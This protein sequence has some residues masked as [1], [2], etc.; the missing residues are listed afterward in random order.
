M[1]NSLYEQD[2]FAWANEQAAL[3]RSGKLHDID[4]ENIAEEIESMDRSHKSE[5]V[6]RLAVLFAASL[7]MA[8]P[9]RVSQ[10]QL[11]PD[12]QPEQRFHIE[13]HMRDN[14]G[15]KSH[16]AEAMTDAFRSCQDQSRA[17]DRTARAEF[18]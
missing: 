16:L 15:L 4:I 12:H 9:A 8:A 17:R 6:N 2:F 14:P 5:L 3:L 11:A 7:E 18:S 10:Q 13:R 1:S